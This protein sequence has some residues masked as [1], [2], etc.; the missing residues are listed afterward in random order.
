M[1]D[2]DFFNIIMQVFKISAVD[3]IIRTPVYIFK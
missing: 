1:K 3:T 2:N